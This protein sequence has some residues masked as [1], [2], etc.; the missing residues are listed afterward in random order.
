LKNLGKARKKSE[1]GKM[2]LKIVG[3]RITKR[4][5]TWGNRKKG[6]QKRKGFLLK[7]V[8]KTGTHG[9][10]KEE[11]DPEKKKNLGCRLIALNGNLEKN[12]EV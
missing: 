6:G 5:E 11:R 4:G 8:G 3:Q 2:T 10:F 12:H 9:S 7:I 1:V